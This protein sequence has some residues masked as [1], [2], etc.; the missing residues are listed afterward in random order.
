MSGHAYSFG[1]QVAL[2][3]FRLHRPPEDNFAVLDKDFD[4]ASVGRETLIVMDR[5]SDSLRDGAVRGIHILLIGGW[6]GR[7][8]F[9]PCFLRRRMLSI[10]M[11]RG[12]C[13][14]Q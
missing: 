7:I 13:G 6:A 4:V 12:K 9:Y 1:F 11:P 5:F 8:P 2:L 14:H 10:G 3:L